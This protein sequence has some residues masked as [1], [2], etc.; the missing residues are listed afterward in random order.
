MSLKDRLDKTTKAP[1]IWTVKPELLLCPNIPK[2]MHGIN[3]RTVL[4]TNWWNRERRAAYKSTAF[5]CEACGVHKSE[6]KL[7][8]W[9]E[10]HEWYQIDYAKGRMKYVRTVPLCH[11]CHN[12]IH[13]GRL[14]RLLDEGLINHQKYAAILQHGE[15]VLR[16]AGLDRM[17][18]IDRDEEIKQLIGNGRFAEWSKWRLVIGRKTYKP[19]FKSYKEWMKANAQGN[20]T[21]EDEEL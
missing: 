5:H 20:S 1:V 21:S 10:G 2:P 17:A 11:Y 18:R 19:L 6:A 16:A 3:P 4:G 8:R 15:A 12:F 13:D 14:R 9:L 7:H